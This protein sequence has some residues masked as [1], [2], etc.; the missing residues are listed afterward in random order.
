MDYYM[1]FLFA[2]V[3][4]LGAV[5]LALINWLRKGE[6]RLDAD[7]YRAKWLNIEHKLKRENPDSYGIVILN[8]D[9]LVDHALKEAGVKG[10]TMGERLKSSSSRFSDLNG[11]WTAHKVRNQI[12]HESDFSVSYDEARKSMNSFKQALKDL[13]AI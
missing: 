7:K 12:A 3:I 1:I 13:G 4:V 2:G 5:L 10:N 6:K 11:L 9:K 8:A